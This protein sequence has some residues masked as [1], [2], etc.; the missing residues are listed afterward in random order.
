LTWEKVD[1]V[2]SSLDIFEVDTAAQITEKFGKSEEKMLLQAL[3]MVF[4]HTNELT[5][6][7]SS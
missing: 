3:F 2:S 7:G 6:V 5:S 4:Y 1:N